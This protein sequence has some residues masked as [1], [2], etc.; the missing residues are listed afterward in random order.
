MG[1]ITRARDERQQAAARR[2]ELAAR[3][4]AQGADRAP[5]DPHEIDGGMTAEMASNAPPAPEMGEDYYTQPVGSDRH[6]QAYAEYMEATG[7]PRAGWTTEQEYA[8]DNWAELEY[9]RRQDQQ[10]AAHLNAD[11]KREPDGRLLDIA[12]LTGDPDA[13]GHQ[14]ARDLEAGS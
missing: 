7:G 10:D 8:A 12:G 1:W 11:R 2:R 13:Y 4:E 5:G 9:D 14:A 6:R 3:R